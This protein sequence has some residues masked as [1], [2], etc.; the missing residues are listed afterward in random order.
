VT[1]TTSVPLSELLT[2]TDEKLYKEILDLEDRM[3][4]SPYQRMVK[5]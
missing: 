5:R 4:C 3:K 1:V 2:K